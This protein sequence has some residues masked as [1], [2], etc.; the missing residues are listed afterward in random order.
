MHL[1]YLSRRSGEL[2]AVWSPGSQLA[3]AELHYIIHNLAA[4]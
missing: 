1:V 3:L 2:P 4:N